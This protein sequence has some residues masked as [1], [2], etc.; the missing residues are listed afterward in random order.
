[1]RNIAEFDADI[2]HEYVSIESEGQPLVN[3][4]FAELA[5]SGP[6]YLAEM[7]AA[8]T[9]GDSDRL[10]RAAHAMKSAVRTLGLNGV[11]DLCQQIELRGLIDDPLRARLTELGEAFSRGLSWVEMQIAAKN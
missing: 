6:Q 11:G 2:L 5:K 1:M 9:A 8:Y 4:L 10:K 3:V 7:G